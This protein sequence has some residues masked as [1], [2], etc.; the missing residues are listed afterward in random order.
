MGHKRLIKMPTYRTFISWQNIICKSRSLTHF[1]LEW[2]CFNPYFTPT[3]SLP[4][5]SVHSLIHLFNSSVLLFTLFIQHIC[6]NATQYT[7]TIADTE[8]LMNNNGVEIRRS[9]YNTWLYHS[10]PIYC[11]SSQ[12]GWPTSI[13]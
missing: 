6:A 2:T 7:Q 5:Y 13:F 10:L 4:S 9:G 11:E 3:L 12:Y 8:T 1:L